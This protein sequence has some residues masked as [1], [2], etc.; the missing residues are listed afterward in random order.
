MQREERSKNRTQPTSDLAVLLPKLRSMDRRLSVLYTLPLFSHIPHVPLI[1]F[2]LHLAS[3]LCRP[4]QC[5]HPYDCR[6]ACER[7]HFKE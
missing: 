7:L 5:I 1:S 2:L 3:N 6:R 4:L